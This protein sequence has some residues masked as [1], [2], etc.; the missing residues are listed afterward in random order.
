MVTHW[1]Y[2]I[3]RDPFLIFLNRFLNDLRFNVIHF[4]VNFEIF[5][6]IIASSKIRGVKLIRK[7]KVFR[8]MLFARARKQAKFQS[9]TDFESSFLRVQK[10]H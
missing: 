8:S 9:E 10:K 4:L 6:E 5:T 2:S 1:Q 3:G 7:S